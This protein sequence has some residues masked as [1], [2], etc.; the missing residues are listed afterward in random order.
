MLG[1]ENLLFTIADASLAA[2]YG[3]VREVVFP[4][5]RGGEQTLRELVHEFKTKEPVYR[6]TVQTTLKAFYTNPWSATT[7]ASPPASATSSRCCPSPPG[8]HIP[9]KPDMPPSPESS[10]AGS[11][12]HRAAC[13]HGF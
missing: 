6:R 12:E 13:P 4:A 10:R 8:L 2:P 11:A 5:V 1:K 3:T 9:T 7:C